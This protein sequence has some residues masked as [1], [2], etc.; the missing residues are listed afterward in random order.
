MG[1]SFQLNDRDDG[2]DGYTVAEMTRQ[3]YRWEE[4]RNP[5]AAP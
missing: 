3:L 5:R 4:T 2:A 1:R